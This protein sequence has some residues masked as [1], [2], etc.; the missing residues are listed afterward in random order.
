MKEYINMN[1]IV[2]HHNRIDIKVGVYLFKEDGFFIAYCPS[3]D[4]T[5]YSDTE[6]MAKDDF[7]FILQDWLEEQ[8][9]N[10]TLNHDLQSHG[11]KLN[12]EGG[13]EPSVDVIPNKEE[14]DRI[15]NLPKYT[16]TSMS[17]QLLCC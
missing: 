8:V 15:I 4:L 16:K 2:I 7:E 1:S 10:N 3:L 5:G 17:A 12:R 13:R 11:C 9:N 6:E 14:I